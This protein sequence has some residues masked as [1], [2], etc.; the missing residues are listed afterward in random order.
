MIQIYRKSCRFTF[1]KVYTA[2]I[3]SK[4][5]SKEA[6]TPILTV[7]TTKGSSGDIVIK[8][9]DNSGYSGKFRIYAYCK[10]K[11]GIVNDFSQSG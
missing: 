11:T 10:D 3:V 8:H 6:N 9:T 4:G 1:D 7:K 2:D 5:I